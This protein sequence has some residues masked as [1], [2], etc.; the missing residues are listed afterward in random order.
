MKNHLKQTIHCLILPA[1][2]FAFGCS[3]TN[4]SK[5]Q[6]ADVNAVNATV[7]MYAEIFA[8]ESIPVSGYGLVGGLNGTGS[9]ECPTDIRTY[10]QKYIKQH[11]GSSKVNVDKLIDSPDTAVVLVE[12]MIPPAASRNQRFD[13]RVS[14]FQGTQTTS[15]EGGWLYGADLFEAHQLGRSM[16]PLAAAEGPV[17]TNTIDTIDQDPKRGYVLGGGS[18]LEDYKVNLSLHQPDYRMAS[19]IRNRIN[20]RYGSETAEAQAPGTIELRIPARYT[21]NKTRFLRL[22]TATYLVETPQLTEKRVMTNIENLISSKEKNSSEIALEAIGNPALPKLSAL[23]NSSDPEIRFH[24]ARCMFNLGDQ[25]GK[26]ALWSIA[27]DKGSSFRMNAI[28]AITNISSG[29]DVNPLLRSLL[30]DDQ[31]AVRLI[32]YE[33]LVLRKDNI[34][35]SRFVANS[36][37]LDQITQGGKPAIL[38]LR[39]D[40]ARVAL[41]GAPIYCRDNI[42]VE[43]QDGAI[44]INVAAGEKYATIIRKHPKHPETIIQL[45][46]SL[47]LADIIETLSSQ[48]VAPTEQGSPGLGVPYS[49]L[50]GLLNK[51]VD[52]GAVAAEIY[53]GPM[54]KFTPIIK[55]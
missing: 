31:M 12:G 1:L 49:L 7:G 5:K 20:E 54:P 48:P 37:Y 9:S 13:V 28:G 18:I 50:V 29:Q 36:F 23:L 25:K 30:Q 14:A 53:L 6:A 39:R 8:S 11:V 46:S 55:K 32:A 42:Y 52:S 15:L 33:N 19:Q 4:T 43:G 22:V 24:A 10:L 45:K 41:L 35:N 26:T 3:Q 16:K 34:V 40:R 38:I 2:L 21:F 17:F 44:T 51:M 27:S 47:N